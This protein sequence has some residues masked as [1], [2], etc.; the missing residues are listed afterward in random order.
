[1]R[2][3]SFV[4]LLLVQV[5][6]LFSLYSQLSTQRKQHLQKASMFAGSGEELNIVVLP[7]FGNAGVDYLNP[8]GL[9]EEYGM[10]AKLRSLG[11]SAQVV[12]IYRLSWLRI[13]QGVTTRRFWTYDSEPQDL[14]SFY[15]E[16][17]QRTVLESFE[18]H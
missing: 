2:G 17:A 16:E 12:P 3:L 8:R 18:I 4:L 9:G 15:L 5:K 6:G 1:M 10:I 7:G 13:A 14:F 11:H